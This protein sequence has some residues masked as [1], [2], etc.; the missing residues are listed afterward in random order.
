MPELAIKLLNNRIDDANHDIESIGINVAKQDDSSISIET[1]HFLRGLQDMYRN[2]IV[3]QQAEIS[4]L[5][6]EACTGAVGPIKQR[7]A[8][9]TFQC[10]PPDSVQVRET[11]DGE[12]IHHK[13]V[14]RD[15]DVVTEIER[16]YMFFAE[17]ADKAR[18]QI[19]RGRT[20]VFNVY[21][22]EP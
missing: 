5:R 4:Q 14:Q 15:H 1:I 22:R 3:S 10:I 6:E 9:I 11:I 8:V 2:R 13:Q 21:F 18:K 17:E 19:M 12:N 16:K 20:C 7:D